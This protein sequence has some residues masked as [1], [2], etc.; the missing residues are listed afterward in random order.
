MM[1]KRDF[2]SGMHLTGHLQQ[3]LIFIDI[4]RANDFF[5]FQ[6]LSMSQSQKKHR[7]QGLYA[8]NLS[9][10]VIKYRFPFQPSKLT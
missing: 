2:R 1:D 6:D 8:F 4:E 9:F 5:F 3:Q 7:T 10:S